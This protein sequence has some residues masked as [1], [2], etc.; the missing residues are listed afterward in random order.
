VAPYQ[1]RMVNMVGTP[2]D[3]LPYVRGIQMVLSGYEGYTKGRRRDADL[4]IRE[5]IKR[6]GT[7]VRNHLLNVHDS[8]FREK[9]IDISKA[10]KACCNTI[11][12]LIEDIDKSPTGMTHA[13]FSGQRSASVSVLKK[14]IK[15]DHDVIEM[16]TKAV[17]I[18]NSVEHAFSSDKTDD[19]VKSLIRQCEQ[20]ITS[21]R[22]YYGA[23]STVLDGLRQKKKV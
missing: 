12:L 11:D 20:M 10:A 17:N 9:K 7:R 22:G 2:L 16:M 15:H 23:R 3:V 19:E 5:E 13:F 6:C 14:L 21:S 18:S 8:A 4:A 1:Y